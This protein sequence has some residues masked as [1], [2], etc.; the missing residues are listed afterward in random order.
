[1]KIKAAR[2]YFHPEILGKISRSYDVV[3]TFTFF[4]YSSI[5]ASFFKSSIKVIRSEVGPIGGI[6]FIKAQQGVY[7][8]LVHF[9]R[10]AYDYVTAYNFIEFRALKKLGFTEDRII[11]VPP[12][13]EFE[14][15]SKLRRESVQTEE[16]IIIGII[17]RISPEKGIHKA[18]PLF[19]LLASKIPDY[20]RRIKL[21][22]AGRIDNSTY[23]SRVLTSLKRVLGSSFIYIGEVASPYGFYKLV[24]IVIVPSLVETGAIVVLEAMASGKCVIASNIYPINQYIIH[25]INGFLFDTVSNAIQ[26]LLNIIEGAID[27][28]KISL[29]AQEEAQKY[30]YRFVCAKLEKLYRNALRH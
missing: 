30:D 8:H 4:T 29:K 16:Q 13:I 15:F 17:G 14:K 11:V 24:D 23:A 10:L 7:S 27:L 22:L 3:H 2:V 12:M 28:N 26:I 21:I 6:N 9:Y 18:I 19:K 25:G 5:L 1:M 20:H